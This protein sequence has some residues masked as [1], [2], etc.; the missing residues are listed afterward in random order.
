MAKI[1]AAGSRP[2]SAKRDAR[3]AIPCIVVL[4]ISM[5]LL[6][7]LFYSIMRNA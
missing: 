2:K 3:G 4:A 5:I 1:R 7:L 6:M